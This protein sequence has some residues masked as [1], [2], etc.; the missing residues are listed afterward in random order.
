M[1]DK[2]FH[3]KSKGGR[4]AKQ[5]KRT[6]L[7]GV[8]CTAAEAFIIK[9]KAEIAG[10]KVSEYLRQMGINGKIDSHQRALPREVLIL[11][12]N[13]NH[14]AANLNQIAKKRNR[15]DQLNAI[16]RA[17]LQH[18]AS[19]LKQLPGEIKKYLQ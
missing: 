18:L 1:E 16:E 10:L 2:N 8:K 12:A 11:C 5:V 3:K 13:L 19:T 17:E 9:G 7:L 15:D 14:S 6:R 4:P